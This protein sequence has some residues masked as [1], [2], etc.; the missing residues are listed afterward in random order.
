ML[1]PWWLLVIGWEKENPF[2][3]HHCH[4]HI[5]KVCPADDS[6]N[7]HEKFQHRFLL[8]SIHCLGNGCMNESIW[9]CWKVLHAFSP[10][11]ILIWELEMASPCSSKVQRWHYWQLVASYIQKNWLSLLENSAENSNFPQKDRLRTQKLSILQFAK[12]R[13]TGIFEDQSELKSLA[14]Q[15]L[16]FSSWIPLEDGGEH[17]LCH[18]INDCIC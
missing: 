7:I 2:L 11:L 1:H 16:G 15:V 9:I 17:T 6:I 10:Q 3:S 5:H 4:H 12:K 13:S 14:E 8:A 18:T